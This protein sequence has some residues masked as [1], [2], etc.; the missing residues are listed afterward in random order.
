MTLHRKY[1]ELIGPCL[2]LI[3][4]LNV[5]N[6]VCDDRVPLKVSFLC[7]TSKST[8]RLYAGAF[9]TALDH[10]NKNET[11]LEG[12]RLDYLFHDTN[13]SSLNS[14]NAMTSDYGNN[15]IGFIGPDHSDTNHLDHFR[16]TMSKLK[17]IC[18]H[19]YIVISALHKKNKNSKNQQAN[20]Q[21]YPIYFNFTTLQMNPL[22]NSLFYIAKISDPMFH[23]RM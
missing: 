9:F 13:E 22:F 15:T 3:A 23:N 2:I 18:W 6:C 14:I 16:G 11:I 1:E 5:P 4:C 19:L 17:Y 20:K 7:S 21:Y 10:V 12:Y 8:A